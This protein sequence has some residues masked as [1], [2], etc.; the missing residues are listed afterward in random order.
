M[1][2]NIENSFK[3]S[4]PRSFVLIL[5]MSTECSLS[6]NLSLGNSGQEQN[7]GNFANSFLQ[8]ASLNIASL[9]TVPVHCILYVMLFWEIYFIISAKEHFITLS[10][11]SWVKQIKT[12][13]IKIKIHNKN[14][15]EIKQTIKSY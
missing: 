8:F 6:K 2:I 12:G 15:N 5:G 9:K 11:T 3:A 14:I 4:F 13:L 1:G 10:H 7:R